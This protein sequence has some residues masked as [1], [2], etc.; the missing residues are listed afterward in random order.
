[1]AAKSADE[2]NDA[3]LAA[4]REQPTGTLAQ[5]F[6]HTDDLLDQG[7]LTANQRQAIVTSRGWILTVLEERGDLAAIGLSSNYTPLA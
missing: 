5:A 4:T 1:M 2:I 3:G 7:A 6:D